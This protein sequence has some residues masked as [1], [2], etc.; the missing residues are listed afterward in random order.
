MSAPHWE[1]EPD[2]GTLGGCAVDG[3]AAAAALDDTLGERQAEAEPVTFGGEEGLERTR[4]FLLGHSGSIVTDA[5]DH[6]L[7]R[8][9]AAHGA[10][11]ASWRRVKFEG[12]DDQI[13]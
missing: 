3:N 9:V 11:D 13:A 2:L 12:I 1:F 5:D 6:A 4:R 7:A 8:P 10:A